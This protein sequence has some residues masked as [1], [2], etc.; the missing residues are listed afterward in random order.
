[1]EDMLEPWLQCACATVPDP[2]RRTE[3]IVPID[4]AWLIGAF[5]AASEPRFA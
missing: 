4:R 2:P 5:L 1:M 3:R